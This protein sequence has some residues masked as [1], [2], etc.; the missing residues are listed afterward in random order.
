M[1][2]WQQRQPYTHNRSTFAQLHTCN[3][4]LTITAL[5]AAELWCEDG[6]DVIVYS[7][8]PKHQFPAAQIR[9]SVF[10]GRSSLVCSLEL[11]LSLTLA[12][13]EANARL[14]K[15]LIVC[16]RGRVTVTGCVLLSCRC[17]TSNLFCSVG[18]HLH[19]Q[20]AAK[21]SVCANQCVHWN[22]T[23]HKTAPRGSVLQ[24]LFL[25]FICSIKRTHR[26][27]WI[28]TFLIWQWQYF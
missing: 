13:S 2:G 14:R 15:H 1:K 26:K 21:A 19:V 28:S 11:Q 12:P 20:A 4:L 7:M 27:T 10:P 18:V 17:F 23:L 5:V 8:A 6:N 22:L 3:A 24:L 25:I 9:E 16:S